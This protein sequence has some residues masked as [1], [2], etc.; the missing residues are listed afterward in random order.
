MIWPT[1]NPIFQRECR[2]ALR[3]LKLR[4]AVL[5]L[6]TLPGLL[7][8]ALWP[9]TGVFSLLDAQELFVVFL[10]SLL[11][12]LCCAT[13]V[14]TATAITD[15]KERHTFEPLFVTCLTPLDILTGKMFSAWCVVALLLAASMPVTALCALSGG[16]SLRF[17]AHSYGISLLAVATYTLM[18]L[19]VS[20]W[21]RRNLQSMLITYLVLLILAGAVWLPGVLLQP[22]AGWREAGLLIRSLS[23]FEALLALYDPALYEARWGRVSAALTVQRHLWGMSGIATLCF[24][25]FCVRIFRP[26]RARRDTTGH[27]RYEDRRTGVKRT[28]HFPFYLIDPLK[29]KQPIANWRNPVFVAEL[30]RKIFGHPKFMLRTLSACLALSLA[31]LLLVVAQ[32]GVFLSPDQVLLST[33]LFQ[34]AIIFFFAPLVSSDS[35]AG[36]RQSGTFEHICMVPL[37]ALTLVIGKVKAAFS[38][39]LILILGSAP[40]FVAILYIQIDPDYMAL[41]YWF[42]ILLCAT[43][44]FTVFGLCA[45][46]FI[47]HTVGA[48]AVS[49]TFA[50]LGLLGTSSVLLFGERIA[51]TTQAAVLMFNPVAAVIQLHSREWL[52]DLPYLFNRPLWQNTLIAYAGLCIVILMVTATRVHH[53]FNRPH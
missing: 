52:A 44:T 35:L 2:A 25:L 49:Y 36:E 29:R 12:L 40:V 8:F 22:F 4:L 13:P 5:I 28:L 51:P 18:G 21:C 41:A 20:A 48:T 11:A 24:V 26:Q 19:A 39:V 6:L 47:P 32:Y 16:I 15:E 27:S 34:F 31:L 14:I 38:Y 46:S 30:R 1:Q 23:P 17:L 3:S 50:L 42:A 45:S 43:L 9:R 33:L 53:L 10:T 7:L 37:T